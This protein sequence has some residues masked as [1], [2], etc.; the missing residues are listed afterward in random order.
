MWLTCYL[1]LPLAKL[2]L[3]VPNLSSGKLIR[4]LINFL[5]LFFN[6]ILQIIQSRQRNLTSLTT[7]EIN[8][9]FK[10]LYNNYSLL[11]LP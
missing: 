2:A 5:Y 4:I 9:Y 3:F 1:I 10:I 8:H 6:N 11:E 7:I